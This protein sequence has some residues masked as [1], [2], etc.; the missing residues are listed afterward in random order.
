MHQLTNL[1]WWWMVG[2]GD[3]D[4]SVQNSFS[5][6]AISHVDEWHVSRVAS[7]WSWEMG[8][9]FRPY[10]YVGLFLTL[11]MKIRLENLVQNFASSYADHVPFWCCM[12]VVKNAY[13]CFSPLNG[14]I[15]CWVISKCNNIDATI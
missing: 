6:S 11:D 8:I 1:V 7:L 15:F 5:R 3:M 2:V 10:T 14:I 12:P 13:P 9:L 4:C